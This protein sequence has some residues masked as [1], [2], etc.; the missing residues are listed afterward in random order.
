MPFS[1][2]QLSYAANHALDYNLRT[3]PVD[4]A[5]T[6]MPLL[7]RLVR[8]MVAWA[9]GLQYITERV[10]FTNDSNFQTYFGDQQVGFNRRRTLD[11]V[12]FPWGNA[13]EGFGLNE[14]ELVQNGITVVDERM[15]EPSENEE[16]QL[17]NLL[18]ENIRSMRN[19]MREGLDLMLHRDGSA[20]ATDIPGIDHLI[21]L[22]PT[23]SSVVGGVNQSTATWWQNNKQTA[24]NSGTP[25]AV[26]AAM[27]K[28][29]R[30]C[31]RFAKTKPNLIL[32]GEDFADAYAADA[33]AAV[34]RQ[35]TVG[36][37]TG[38]KA[39][40]TLDAAV[41]VGSSNTGLFYD[42]VPAQW[43]P[44]FTTLQTLDSET[45]SWKKRC[46]FINTRHMRLRPIK[47]HW[48][49]ARKPARVPDRYVHYTA[50]TSKL[51]LTTNMRNA[52]AVLAIS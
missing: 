23:V 15:P 30:N 19:G 21:Q 10:H 43:D 33:K 2:E 3:E 24:I 14:D 34:S 9:G 26:V 16:V 11:T 35:V 42:G 22:D 52:H 39:A 8:E 18:A 25:G 20:S 46:Y 36:G 48:M 12:K 41:V 32:M 49:K 17:A 6:E 40:T 44:V 29:W 45:T 5:T 4:Q 7:D 37:S 1:P 28:Q 38:N 13:H 27:D 51:S 31:I 47:G 50:M